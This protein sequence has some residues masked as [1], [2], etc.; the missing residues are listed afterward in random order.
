MLLKDVREQKGWVFSNWELTYDAGWKEILKAV[1]SVYDY[2]EKREILV[3]GTRK[4]V[5]DK[6]AVLSLEEGSSL[7]VRGISTILRVP[8]MMVFH[9]NS[10][11]LEVAVGAVTDEFKGT[12]YRKFNTSMCQY[13][14]SIEIAMYR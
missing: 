2:H 4:A 11:D 7:T 5:P 6:E 14:T 8:L 12:D 1:R 13:M 9:K 10:S 3:D